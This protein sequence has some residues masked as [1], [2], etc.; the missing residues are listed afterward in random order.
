MSKKA[1]VYTRTGDKGTT[2][3]GNM[4]IVPKD[5]LRVECYGTID[6][7]NSVIGISLNYFLE[8][9]TELILLKIQNDLLLLG[10]DIAFPPDEDKRKFQI[11][12]DHVNWVEDQIDQLDESL[13]VL[14]NFIIPGGAK[15]A[16]FI[17]LAR[18]V[19]RRAERIYI[20]L[21]REIDG[22]PEARVYINRLSDL[23]FTISR[24]ENSKKSISEPIWKPE[25]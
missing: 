2:M 8:S 18:T 16:A 23:L 11:E 4:E 1:K 17:H 14:T 13:P 15:G 24:F 20:K 7:L 19:C 21:D 10:A 25:Y 6:E 22:N 5:D 9:E 12:K 3:L